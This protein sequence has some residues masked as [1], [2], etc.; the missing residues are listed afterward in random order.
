MRA[1]GRRAVVA[2]DVV[3]Q[4]VV[5]DAELLQAVEQ[6]ADVV[7][8][9]LH[10]AGV[11]F[12]LAAQDRLEV[13]RHLVPRRDFLVARGELAV[14]RDDAELLLPGEGLLAQLVPALRRTCPCTC[15]PTPWARGAARG[16]RRARSRRRTACRARAPS[17]GAI[18]FDGLVGHV[19]HEVVA[20]FGR[21]LRLDRRGAL[22]ERRIP[23]VG[24]AADE[25]V[26]V[27]EAAAARGPGVERPDR[28][29]LPHRHFVA[30]AELRR[31]VAVELERLG[32][33][34]H[35]VGQHRAVARRAGG[36]LG[37]AAHAGGVVVAAGQQRLARRRA[38]RGGVEAVELQTARRQLLRVRRLA[39]TAEGAGRA[40]AGVV[41]QDDEH[42]GRTLG[43]PQLLDRRKLTV[44][45]LRV[46]GNEL[47]AFRVRHRQMRTVF[48]IFT[49]HRFSSRT[50]RPYCLGRQVILL[51]HI[52]ILD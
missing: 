51:F 46:V 17:A 29:R 5:E 25:A 28:A 47:G 43:R 6:P 48:I 14:R 30:L 12:H 27:L 42:V 18:Q 37:D 20:L 2:D 34:R 23:L 52:Y 4:R 3:D 22:V 36:D 7:V 44:R 39:G 35:G 16:W 9:V 31:V 19:L 26:E 8:G 40:E 50:C 11:D 38:E 33:R 49:T 1:L 21:L 13:L 32:Q 41:D 45:V 15:R 10:E 24:L